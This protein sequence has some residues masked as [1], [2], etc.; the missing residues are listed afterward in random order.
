MVIAV[1]FH[2]LIKIK[3]VKIVFSVL[4]SYFLTLIIAYKSL[5]YAQTQTTSKVNYLFKRQF[6]LIKRMKLNERK[7]NLNKINIA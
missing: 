2:P 4:L 5:R 3:F 1:L 7:S 6:Y